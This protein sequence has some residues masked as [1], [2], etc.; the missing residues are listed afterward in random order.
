MVDI[1]ALFGQQTLL[2]KDTVIFITMIDYLIMSGVFLDLTNI[3]L[4]FFEFLYFVLLVPVFLVH[5]L[6]LYHLIQMLLSYNVSE[7]YF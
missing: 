7:L 3:E 1:V 5:Y 4:Q 2:L 6:K